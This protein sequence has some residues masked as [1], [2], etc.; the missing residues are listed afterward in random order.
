MKKINKMFLLTIM[1][2]LIVVATGIK[3]GYTKANRDV[4]AQSL[5]KAADMTAEQFDGNTSACWLRNDGAIVN[6]HATGSSGMEW[7]KGSGK[8]IDFASGIWLVGKDSEGSIRTA[9]SEYASEFVPGAYGVADGPQYRIYKINSDGTGDWDVWPVDQGAPVNDDGTPKLIGDQTLFWVMNDGDQAAHANL[10]ST[11]PMGI[12]VRTT[13]FGFNSADPLGNVMFFN[14]EVINKG[15]ETLDSCFVGLWDDPDLGDASDDLVGCDTTLSLG[16]CYNGGPVD[17]TYGT[18]PP[19]I[20]MDF[21]QGPLV[22]GVY[23]PM[24]SFVYYW[25][26]APDPFGD[27]ED[28]LQM[29]N[30][31]KGV[32]SDGSAYTNDLGEPVKFVFAGD[33]VTGAGH[34][35]DHADDRRFLMSSGPFVLKPGDTQ[36]I[37]GSKII[38]PGTD[39]LSSITALRFFDSYAQNAFDND[40]VLPQP[41]GPSVSATQEG[42]KIVLT[43]QDDNDKYKNIESYSFNGYEFEGYNVYMGESQSGPWKLIATYDVINDIGITFDAVFDP[44]TGM[45]LEKPVTF[46]ANSGLT[47]NLTIDS[48]KITGFPLYNYKNYYFNVSSYAVNPNVSPKVAESGFKAVTVMPYTAPL[49]ILANAAVDEIIEATHTAGKSDG[50][51][52]A[53]VVSPTELTTDTYAVTFDTLAGESVWNLTNKTT[54]A[55]VL[56]NQANQTGDDDYMIADGMKVFVTG[57]PLAIKDWDYEGNRW[58]SG[59]NWGGSALFGGMDL[60]LFFFGSTITPPEYVPILMEW[61][62]QAGVDANGYSGKGAYYHRPGY[63]HMGTMQMPFAAYDVSDPDNPRRVNVSAVE[64]ADNS[65]AIWDMGWDGAAFAE[66]GNREYLFIHLSDYDEGASYNDDNWAPAAD[67]L[68]AI[69]PT[70]RGSRAYLLA[71]FTLTI[72]PNFV[73]TMVDEFEF[74]SKGPDVSAAVAEAQLDDINVVPNPYW[75]WSSNETQPTTRIIRFTHMPKDGATIRIFDLAGNL[76]KSITDADREA[77]GTLGTATA[78]WDARNASDVPVASGMYL[79]HVTVEGVG[80]K[81]LKLAVINRDERLIYY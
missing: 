7:P 39:N 5:A 71:E 68:Y 78:Q 29:F 15:G 27:P 74:T 80:E 45:V 2:S 42:G 69:W 50:A 51:V 32:T 49:G 20:G 76:V 46:G 4:G 64:A 58:I 44:G 62:D 16:Y 24:T 30:F 34:I 3:F 70:S 38:A 72:E 9:G 35:D 52:F 53:Q 41:P 13:V 66:S 65:N 81:V 26:G 37:V 17:A 77:Q 73:N 43:W 48:D 54:G 19:A 18:T 56:T 23:M 11:K 63:A 57:P 22:D 28:G 12:E 61:Q 21:F 1:L 14:F 33:P 36:V 75:A 55:T 47:R 67:V 6:Y 60:G 79:V 59:T 25:N 8:T 10:W 31:M 40:F